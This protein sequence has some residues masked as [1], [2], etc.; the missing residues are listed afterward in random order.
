[1]LKYWIRIISNVNSFVYRVYDML[2]NAVSQGVSSTSNNWAAQIKSILDDLG[3]SGVWLNQ[4]HSV[5]NIKILKQRLIDQ[6]KQMWCANVSQL[7]KLRYYVL[8]KDNF[9]IEP[10]KYLSCIV[11]VRYRT[12]LAKLG[13]HLIVWK[14]KREDIMES[15]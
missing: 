3:F 13:C 4:S 7:S 2:Y 5:P 1:M 9:V 10:E 11:D 12:V 6:Y 15:V 14:L 8:F